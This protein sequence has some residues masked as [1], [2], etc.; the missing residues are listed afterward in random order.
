MGLQLPA[1][2]TP[3]FPCSLAAESLGMSHLFNVDCSPKL[4]ALQCFSLPLSHAS[5]SLSLS[6]SHLLNVFCSPKLHAL[7]CF[8]LSLSHASLSLSLSLSLSSPGTPVLVI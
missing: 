5:L 8:S 7:Q 4:H 2:Q 1:L 3:L 6:M